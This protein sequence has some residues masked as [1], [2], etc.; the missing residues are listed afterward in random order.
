[1]PKKEITRYSAAPVG[2]ELPTAR[3]ELTIILV[4][5]AGQH[6]PVRWSGERKRIAVRLKTAVMRLVRRP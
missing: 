6:E 5:L 3:A 2:F 1:M 4:D